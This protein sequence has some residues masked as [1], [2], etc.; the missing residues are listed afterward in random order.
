MKVAHAIESSDPFAGLES[1]FDGGTPSPARKLPPVERIGEP[2]LEDVHAKGTRSTVARFPCL[3]CGGSGRY[4]GASQYGSKCFK[5]GGRGMMKT[6][7]MARIR[8]RQKKAERELAERAKKIA[9]WTEANPKAA[10]WM[11]A[12]AAKFDF[13][14]SMVDALAKWGSLTDGQTAA[15]YRC[16]EKNAERAKERA[17]RKP[18]AD[19]AGVGFSRMI[20][21]FAAAT[22][23][24]L[25]RPKFHVGE[26]VFS[27]AKATSQN[28]GSIYVKN[29]GTYVGKITA[30]G[31]FFASREATDHDKAEVARIGA[32]P[33][34]AAVMHGK[35][36]G[37]CSCCSRHLENEESVE[38]GIGP[39]CRAKWGLK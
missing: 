5:C 32:D 14:R 30:E 23:S 7:P 17:E 20:A 11:A 33:L 1:D 24:G 37:N 28:A 12:N 10:E 38:L 9:A 6:D 8:A 39:I 18:D 25:K 16:I 26:F 3:K 29:G 34:A 15:I 35:Q 2:T 31:A 27:P 36:T 21:A 19:V 13:A 4:M 22:L